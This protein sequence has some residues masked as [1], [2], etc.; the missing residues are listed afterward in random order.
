MGRVN[1][2]RKIFIVALTALIV[3]VLYV[4]CK[5]DSSIHPELERISALLDAHEND[6][7][8]EALKAIDASQV[9]TSEDKALYG[10]LYS[11]GMYQQFIPDTTGALIAY[12][13]GYYEGEGGKRLAR[14]YF[15]NAVYLRRKKGRQAEAISFLKKSGEIAAKVNDFE[16]CYRVNNLLST[17]NNA[18]G[19]QALGLKYAKML[20][21]N[22]NALDGDEWKLAAYNQ[23]AVSF[24]N[25]GN[26]DSAVF[27]INKCIP[28]LDQQKPSKM[29]CYI[30]SNIGF[31]NRDKNPDFALKYS[32]KSLEL[33]P[34]TGPYRDIA[35][36]YANK[37]EVAKAD[38]FFKLAWG[39]ASLKSKV[40]LAK[41]MLKHKHRIGDE[42]ETE[43]WALTL[44]N[45]KDSLTKQQRAENVEKAQADYE[46]QKEMEL[47]NR[48]VEMLVVGGI[49]S[50]VFTLALGIFFFRRHH[51]ERQTLDKTISRLRT[52]SEEQARIASDQKKYIDRMGSG[53]SEG[54]DNGQR[55][56]EALKRKEE[57]IVRWTEQD[58][59]DFFTY[60][61]LKDSTFMT[62]LKTGYTKLSNV[63]KLYLV[64]VH[65]GW[66]AEDIANVLGVKKASLRVI[67][68]R[69]ND[70]AIPKE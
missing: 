35:H 51:R 44:V 11:Q 30:Y 54:V 39:L 3:A 52:D 1:Y 24:Q 49:A 29:L 12:S 67:K 4:G 50:T 2:V 27:Y 19:E 14:S 60:Y 38:S 42:K 69:A 10:L 16:T 41:A 9:T 22:A 40:E 57:N 46:Y 7:A 70:K 31:F 15:Y 20:L 17:I 5:Q 47:S 8:W 61:Y 62:S 43:K 59:E 68:K 13:I 55:I 45:L 34:S 58:F 36:I 28:L 53:R 25:S 26:K 65:E 63:M 21:T 56:Y 48:K 37:G 18:N 33:Q 6:V 23:V 32:R 66:E 64:L